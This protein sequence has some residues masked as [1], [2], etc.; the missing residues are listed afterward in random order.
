M[1]GPNAALR[2]GE[3]RKSNASTSSM[4]GSARASLSSNAGD[5]H[6]HMLP[7]LVLVELKEIDVPAYLNG[8]KGVIVSSQYLDSEQIQV[9]RVFADDGSIVSVGAKNLRV[10][11][12]ENET[13]EHLFNDVATTQMQ[14]RYN[15]ELKYSVR[16]SRNRYAEIEKWLKFKSQ[17]EAVAVDTL[18]LSRYFESESAWTELKEGE[19]VVIVNESNRAHLNKLSG[20]CRGYDKMT[21]QWVVSLDD[22]SLKSLVHNGVA[23][24]DVLRTGKAVPVEQRNLC[25]QRFYEKENHRAQYRKYMRHPTH[26]L[27]KDV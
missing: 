24:S 22:S 2:E 15:I 8:L 16:D 3:A 17:N 1:G 25:T 26:D 6:T 9:C 5:V 20:V 11:H 18:D 21:R 12:G 10:I 23:S 13:Y 4:I 19:P 14:E 7:D 27:P